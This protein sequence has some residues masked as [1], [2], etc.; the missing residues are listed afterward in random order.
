MNAV[1][2]PT[3]TGAYRASEIVQAL[4]QMPATP[5]VLPRLQ[6]LLN[7]GNS[8]IYDIVGL[9]RLDPGIAARVLQI[10]NSVYFGKGGARVTSVED[11]VV[12]VGYDQIYEL[13][14]H[15][16]A[17]A[18]FTQPLFVYG[19]EAEDLWERAVSCALAAE[20]IASLVGED[21]SVAYTVGLLHGVGM[22]AINTWAMGHQPVLVFSNSGIAREY[23]DS[24]RA[25][26]GLMQAEVGAELLDRWEFPSTITGP[27]RWQYSPNA[28]MVHLRMAALLNLAKW[29]R[30]DVCDEY[31]DLPSPDRYVMHPLRLSAMQI[32]RVSSEVKIRMLAVRHL[33]ELE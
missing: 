22:L 15:A 7:D 21:K 6:Q 8:S 33:L 24:E 3:V 10:A 19:I 2:H 12:R 9:V 30:A 27:V 17:S 29:V 20:T 1:A 5:K 31:G 11:A 4:S 13:V 18:I 25:L 28:S 26:V 16:V 14:S 32:E 23:I